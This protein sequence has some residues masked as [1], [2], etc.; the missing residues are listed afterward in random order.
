MAVSLSETYGRSREISIS[1]GPF[2]LDER[3]RLWYINATVGG[4]TIRMPPATKVVKAGGPIFMIVMRSG[5]NTVTIAD[6][7]GTAI[8]LSDGATTLAAL[9]CAMML[10]HPPGDHESDAECAH[11]LAESDVVDDLLI[12]LLGVDAVCQQAVDC[13]IHLGVDQDHVACVV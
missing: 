5:S 11:A 7:A 6:N 4:L 3:T 13:A 10:W 2:T 9:R 8:T 12:D 1:S